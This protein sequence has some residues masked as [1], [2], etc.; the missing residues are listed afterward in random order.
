MQV[1]LVWTYTFMMYLLFSFE[2]IQLVV[3]KLQMEL[4]SWNGLNTLFM[5]FW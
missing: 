1:V 3:V 2:D 5:Y 4:Y